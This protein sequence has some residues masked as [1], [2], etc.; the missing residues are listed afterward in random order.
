MSH[1]ILG[2]PGRGEGLSCPGTHSLS[3]LSFMAQWSVSSGPEARVKIRAWY[4]SVGGL[5]PLTALTKSRRGGVRPCLTRTKPVVHTAGLPGITQCRDMG[6]GAESSQ[7]IWGTNLKH[8]YEKKIFLDR[9][10]G[11]FYFPILSV[12]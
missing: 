4:M 3:C 10:L 12:F 11:D 7:E 2:L 8:F 9:I 6:N 1:I 5:F